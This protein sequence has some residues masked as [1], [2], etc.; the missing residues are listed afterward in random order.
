VIATN[1][2][3]FGRLLKRLGFL[4]TPASTETFAAAIEALGFDRRPEIRAAGRAIYTRRRDERELFDRAFGLFWRRYHDE[5]SDLVLPRMRQDR[6][7]PPTFPAPLP[8]TEGQAERVTS[9]PVTSLASAAEQLRHADFAALTPAEARDALAMLARLRPALPRRP[10]RRWLVGRRGRRPARS[11]MLRSSLSTLGEPVRWQWLRHPRRPRPIVLIADISGSMERY[12]RLVLRFAHA[13]AQAGAPLEVFVFGTRLTRIT[14]ELKVRD[15]DAAL[16]RVGHTV[17]DWNGGTRIGESIRELNQRWV[18]RTIRSGAV[19][20]LVSDGWERGD[21]ALLGV[22]MA[23]LR[24]ACYRLYWLDPL[25]SQPGFVPTVAGLRAA[26]PHVDA[27]LACASVASLAELGDQLVA[28]RR[29]GSG[30]AGQRGSGAAGQRGSGA[31][32]VSK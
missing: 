3:A 7:R 32:R 23:R 13:L 6:A 24:R 12:S 21:P 29:E 28:A 17:V 10:S 14:R 8:Q 25:A 18:R 2:I 30:A 31:A 20:L 5:G 11:R 9:R 4:V 15:P 27:L 19:V 1:L 22:E 26:L 16:E